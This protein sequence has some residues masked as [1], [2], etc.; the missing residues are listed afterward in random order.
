M[1]GISV[2]IR[3]DPRKN[4]HL[5]YDATKKR[6]LRTRKWTVDIEPVCASMLD[7]LTYKTMRKKLV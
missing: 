5:S 2:V 4:Y 7:F 3:K 6:Q 1:N